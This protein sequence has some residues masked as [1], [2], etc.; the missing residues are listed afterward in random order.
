MSL[1]Q[2]TG[3]ALPVALLAIGALLLCWSSVVA[4]DLR[5][6]SHQSWSTQ[7]GLPQSSVH[8][9]AQTHDGYIWVATEAGLA[10]FDGTTFQVFDHTSQ[11][12]FS[13]DDLCCLA[14]DAKDSLWI[15]TKD[16]LIAM[17]NGKFIR[18]GTKD[19][20]PSPEIMDLTLLRDGSLAV[21]TAAGPVTRKL[22][23][24]TF[25][26]ATAELLQSVPSFH[27]GTP[28]NGTRWN[29]TSNEVESS[30]IENQRGEPRRLW[31]AGRELRGDRISSFS[32]DRDG[33]GWVGTN[34]GLEVLNAQNG[35]ATA[36][37]WLAADSILAI[38]QDAEGN[39]WIG[40]ETSGLH[41]LRRTMFRSVAALAGKA[42]TSVAQTEDGAIWLGTRD[43]GLR[44]VREGVTDQPVANR[45]LTSPVILCLAPARHGGLWVGTPD[46]LNYVDPRENVRHFTSVNGLPDDYIR[47]L[48]ADPDGSLW[49]GTRHGLAHLRGSSW[50]TLTGSDGLGADL[51]GALLLVPAKRP[52]GP[53]ELWVSTSG[54]LSHIA[55]DGRISNLKVSG[56]ASAPIVT[57]LA[58]DDAGNLWAATQGDGLNVVRGSNLIPVATI[59]P[60]S[61]RVSNVEAMVVDGKGNLWLRMDRGIWR[62]SIASLDDCLVRPSC[63]LGDASFVKYDRADGLPNEEAL[64]GETS[65]AWLATNGELW[66]STRGG[67]AVTDTR[68]ISANSLPP[69]VVLQRFLVDDVPQD[70][71]ASPLKLAFGHTR[72]TVEYAALSYTA[73]A[74][75]RYRFRLEPFD[76]EWTDAGSRRSATYTNLPPAAY[77]FQVQ[78]RSK[79]GSWN[80]PGNLAGAELRFQV[81]PPFYRRWWFLVLAVLALL[82]LLAGVYLRRLRRLRR[83]FDAVL[84]ERNRMARE[85][86]DTLTQDFVSTSLQLDILA[87]QLQRGHIEKA[88]EQVRHARQLVTE[89]LAEAR[90]SI[91]ELRANNSQDTLPTRLNRLLQRASFAALAPHLDVSG[92]YRSIDPRIER[93]LLRLAQEAL[94]NAQRHAHAT[95]TKVGL[96]YSK[97]ALMLTI[98]DNGVGFVVDDASRIEGHYGLLGMRERVSSIDGSLEIVSKP[99]AGTIIKVR[100]PLAP[101]GR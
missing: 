34:N 44:R 12:A 13:S 26:P 40:T 66:F 38:F 7:E 48:A 55:G 2:Q 76:K 52:G 87:Q 32:S 8:A 28:L 81:V 61:V 4:Q 99:D 74:A 14:V 51:I 42:V 101:D 47:S 39:H 49:V 20:L 27:F 18:Y 63:T 17:Q 3:R 36:V 70:L 67:V 19:G 79:D 9:I 65:A 54:G 82:A 15:G 72:L 16:G 43:D 21:N 97:D 57:A 22:D 24:E 95:S 77:R 56:G 11:P 96:H 41:I 60:D 90:Q 75:V 86:H 68:D 50:E 89:G 37:T 31:R 100:V 78:A 33:F 30:Q 53:G 64:P 91:W 10:R 58:R 45:L 92:A 1:L 73:P 84:A 5:Y 83:Q 29:W 69:P 59:Y 94:S 93:E 23:A 98:E 25:S 71:Q 85:I 35:S 46:G 88:I 62:V 80:D 6:L